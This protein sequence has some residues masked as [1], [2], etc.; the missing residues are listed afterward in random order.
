MTLSAKNAIEKL[1]V[2]AQAGKLDDEAFMNELMETQVFV[3]VHEKDEIG[4]L[5]STLQAT[6]LVL[7]D[8]SGVEVL[9]L[10]T[11]SERAR[12]VIESYPGYHDGLFAE[13]KWV[14][15]KMAAGYAISINPG[16]EL[17]LD[18]EV[19]TVEKLIRNNRG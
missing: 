4:G 12:T 18:L 17:G 1:F 11:S 10:F 5:Q 14:V 6:P 9:I 8:K 13:F 2:K 7:K 19:S 15:E 16:H 3:P